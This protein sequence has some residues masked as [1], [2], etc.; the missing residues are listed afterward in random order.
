MWFQFILDS[1]CHLSCKAF[2]DLEPVSIDVH[3]ASQLRYTK[4]FVPRKVADVCLPDKW[5]KVMFT[6]AGNIDVLDENNTAVIKIAVNT[7][8]QP[9][10]PG[11]PLHHAAAAGHLRMVELLLKKG[12]DPEGCG[13][14]GYKPLLLALWKRHEEIAI[15]LFSKMSDP[16]VQIAGDAGYT[17]LHVASLRQSP[18][19]ARVFLESGADV[20]VRT[21]KGNTPLHLALKPKASDKSNDTTWSCTLEL[22]ILLLEFR[23][24]RDTKAYKLGMQHS[25]PQVREIFG[26]NKSLPPWKASFISVGR[27]WSVEDSSSADYVFSPMPANLSHSWLQQSSDAD[28]EDDSTVVAENLLNDNVF[29]VLNPSRPLQEQQTSTSVWDPLNVKE[30]R[31]TMLMTESAD[32]ETSSSRVPVEPFPKLIGRKSPHPLQSA[33]QLSWRDLRSPKMQLVTEEFC[34]NSKGEIQEASSQAGQGS[35]KRRWRPLQLT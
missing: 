20:N 22:V 9:L 27:P 35:K 12:G 32:G 13:I 5:Q 24:D 18:K 4:D 3:N 11:T 19:S 10:H 26:G 16:N 8:G 29:P 15:F 30:I 2:L 1:I 17:P 23:S 21:S 7:R 14:K 31:R 28:E 6:Q 33:A 34:T 25:D